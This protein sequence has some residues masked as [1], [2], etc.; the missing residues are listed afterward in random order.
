MRDRKYWNI[1]KFE[2]LQEKNNFVN[3]KNNFVF[4]VLLQVHLISELFGGYLEEV[5]PL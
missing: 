2:K 5:G 4:D 1:W 3:K